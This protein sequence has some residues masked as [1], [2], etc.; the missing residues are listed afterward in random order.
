MNNACGFLEGNVSQK[1]CHFFGTGDP[2]CE[3][4]S[5]HSSASFLN[6]KA[7][8]ECWTERRRGADIIQAR[9][10]NVLENVANGKQSLIKR[11]VPL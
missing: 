11:G 2:G 6:R 7:E 4:S 10:V 5:G 8:E 1:G 9:T 3:R